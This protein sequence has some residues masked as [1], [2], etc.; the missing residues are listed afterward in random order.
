MTAIACYSGSQ[1]FLVRSRLGADRLRADY[2]RRQNRINPLLSR[3]AWDS[4][5]SSPPL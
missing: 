1:R 3:G 4:K 5:R 2:R